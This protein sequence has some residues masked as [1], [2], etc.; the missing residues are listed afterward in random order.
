MTL[1]DGVLATLNSLCERTS[2]SVADDGDIAVWL[3]EIPVW[4]RV[5]ESPAAVTIY[6]QVVDEVPA[7]FALNEKLND[8]NDRLVVFRAL[9]DDEKVFL[10]ADMPAVPFSGEH[11]QSVLET[12]QA[13]ADALAEDLKETQ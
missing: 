5:H 10:R 9:R 11:L 8:L 3:G 6:R 12:F 7:S 2:I 4:V 1:R 13:E